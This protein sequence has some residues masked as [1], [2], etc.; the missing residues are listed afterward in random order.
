MAHPFKTFYASLLLLAI[1][2]LWISADKVI[3]K[4]GNVFLGTIVS[5]DTN[6]IQIKTD[7]SVLQIDKGDVVSVTYDKEFE[8]FDSLW[9]SAVLPGFGQFWH[10]RESFGYLYASLTGASLAIT[11]FSYF[12]FTSARSSYYNNPYNESLFTKA[13]SKRKLFNKFAYIT[14][15]IWIWQAF[16][17]FLFCP[18]PKYTIPEPTAPYSFSIS[19]EF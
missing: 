9:R 13:D 7:F 10:E 6:T 12:N 16:D 5:H 4:N 18:S 1:H 2:P 15:T 17:A 3:L 11:L 19:F 14:A 8:R